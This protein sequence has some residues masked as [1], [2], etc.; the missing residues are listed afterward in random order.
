MPPVQQTSMF[1]D[2]WQHVDKSAN[3]KPSE[4][5]HKCLVHAI[6]ELMKYLVF[7]FSAT[8]VA[9][10]FIDCLHLLLLVPNIY[11]NIISKSSADVRR[12]HTIKR[13]KIP[14]LDI[15]LMHIKSQISFNG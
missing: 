3:V 6:N 1:V 9:F 8:K 13:L 7:M 11:K 10:I 15:I 12:H 4:S 14:W 2:E 5:T